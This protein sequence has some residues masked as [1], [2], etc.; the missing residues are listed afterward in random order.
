MIALAGQRIPTK[1]PLAASRR[2]IERW[3]NHFADLDH[4]AEALADEMRLSR[5]DIGV[6]L[7]ERL[8]DRHPAFGAHPAGRRAAQY[9]VA[10]RSSCAS[11][12]VVRNAGSGLAQFSSRP[13]NQPA[14]TAQRGP[15]PLLRVQGSMTKA[16]VIYSRVIWK[17]YFAAAPADALWPLPSR[18]RGDKLRSAGV[19]ASFLG[20]LR[21]ACT[22]PHHHAAGSGNGGC[23]SSCCGS[24]GQASSPSASSGPVRRVS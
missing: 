10:A 16:R 18:M 15:P 8:R 14:R 21:T 5:A 4:A 20:K 3:R 6:A 19:A 12:P 22:S 7:T 24:T 11:G 23:R 1:T 9:P 13:E 17:D 2:E